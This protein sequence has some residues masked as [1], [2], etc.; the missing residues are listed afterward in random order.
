MGNWQI[1]ACSKI[2]GFWLLHCVSNWQTLAPGPNLVLSVK[3]LLG[4]SGTYGTSSL[5]VKAFALKWQSCMVVIDTVWPAKPKIMYFLALYRKSLLAPELHYVPCKPVSLGGHIW[6]QQFLASISSEVFLGYFGVLACVLYAWGW[7]ISSRWNVKCD[8]PKTS[9]TAKTKAPA[10]SLAS[11]KRRHSAKAI[12]YSLI[13]TRWEE[14]LR[15]VQ[16]LQSP[17]PF[18]AII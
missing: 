13:K 5:S 15:V 1:Q 10:R 2:F 11:L 3:F 14:G 9:V 7:W 16:C 4:H 12:A 6:G 8:F 18:A 17:E